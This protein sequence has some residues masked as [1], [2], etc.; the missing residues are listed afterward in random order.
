MTF[1]EAYKKPYRNAYGVYISDDNTKTMFNFLTTDEKIQNRIVDLMNDV[2][3]TKP[4]KMVGI[5][6]DKS[7]VYIHEKAVLLCRG[8]GYLTGVGGL[9]LSTE[10]ATKIQE[11]MV[12]WTAYKIAGKE[13]KL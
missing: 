4:F 9:H 5:N 1:E 2:P 6:S 8:W 7:V 13:P 11:D 3:G 12:T 10:E